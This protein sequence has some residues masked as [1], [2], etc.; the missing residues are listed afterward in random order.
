MFCWWFGARGAAAVLAKPFCAVVGDAPGGPAALLANAGASVMGAPA[1]W[2]GCVGLAA[3]L[4]PLTV[5]AF[6]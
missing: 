4:G 3:V 5:D 6:I 1:W 2:G